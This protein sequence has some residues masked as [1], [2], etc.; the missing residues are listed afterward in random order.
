[1]GFAHDALRPLSNQS[2]ELNGR[3]DLVNRFITPITLIIT[4]FIPISNLLVKSP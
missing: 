1:M 2:Y 4:L 3:G